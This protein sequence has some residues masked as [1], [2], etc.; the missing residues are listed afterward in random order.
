MRA[1]LERVL[2]EEFFR[3]ANELQDRFT[4][5]VEEAIREYAMPWTV[6]R[7]GLRSEYCFRAA[8]PRNGGE[9]AL[10]GD[11]ELEAF[12]HLWALNRGIL[13]TPFHNMALTASCTRSEDVDAHTA[14]FRDALAALAGGSR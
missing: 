4:A 7:L 6:E 14:V 10:A 11:G 2:T 3:L 1:T 8:S 5:G 12:M 9:A 13:L